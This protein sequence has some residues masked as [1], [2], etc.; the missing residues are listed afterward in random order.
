M[1]KPSVSPIQIKRFINGKYEFTEDLLA[2]EEP[3]EI[4]LG[5]GLSQNRAQQRISVTMRTPGNDFELAIGFLF[6]EGIIASIQDILT[7]QYCTEAQTQE[8]HFNVI[9]VELKENVDFDSAT[10]QRNFYTSS[11]CGVCGKASIDAVFQQ[12]D[13]KEKSIFSISPS[14]IL[15]LSETLRSQQQVFKYTG[16]LHGCGLF[17]LK[18]KLLL[19]REDVGRHNA[20][21]KL[22]GAALGSDQNILEKSMLVLSGRA[23]FELLQKAAMAQIPMVVSVGA[24]SSLA[25]ETAKQFDIT[26]IGFVKA[27][28]FNI[29]AGAQ[30]L[31]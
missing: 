13:T 28:K 27:D 22:I 15:A 30:R 4:R 14:V 8:Q 10:L 29:Y 7:I 11:S 1:Q 9:R 16:G 25:V 26:L 18:G 31:N 12:C 21:D 20:L 2:V 5:F 17:D 19:S 6:T 23:S 3:L 24:P